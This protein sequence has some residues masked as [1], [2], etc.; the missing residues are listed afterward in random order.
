MHRVDLHRWGLPREL[1]SGRDMEQFVRSV[2]ASQ[3]GRVLTARKTTF[4]GMDAVDLTTEI[5]STRGRD[6]LFSSYWNGIGRIWHDT[7]WKRLYACM[8]AVPAKVRLLTDRDLF[9]S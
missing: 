5:R 6:R 4:H 1:L 3:E 9:A 2:V 8:Q 7:A